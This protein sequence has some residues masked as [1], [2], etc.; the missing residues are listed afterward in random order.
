MHYWP[1]STRQC[2]KQKKFLKNQIKAYQSWKAKADYSFGL[3]NMSWFKLSVIKY[4]GTNL[5]T[6]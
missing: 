3:L 5:V 1:N 4:I 6:G 2:F